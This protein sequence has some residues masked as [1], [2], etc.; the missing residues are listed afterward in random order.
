MSTPVQAVD[1]FIER[2]YEHGFYT[3]IESDT[4]APGL[5]EDVVRL[6]SSKKNEPEF[7]LEWRLRA[8]RQWLEMREIDFTTP[9]KILYPEFDELLRIS[10]LRETE[11]FFDHVLKNDLSVVNFVDSDFTFLNGRLAQH[12]EID[13][14]TGQDFRQVKLPADGV[15]GGLT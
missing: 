1:G 13:G 10:M 15:R 11:L 4:V 5:N 6:I 2:G 7:M 3:D 8:Y 12:Y 14:V 9:D